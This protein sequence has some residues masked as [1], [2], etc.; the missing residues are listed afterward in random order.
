MSSSINPEETTF[1]REFRMRVRNNPYRLGFAET[2]RLLKMDRSTLHRDC[3][4]NNFPEWRTVLSLAL[5]FG[6]N[7]E[8]LYLLE[9][10]YDRD[11]RDKQSAT[12]EH[13]IAVLREQR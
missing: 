1:L 6:W 9:M 3:E 7:R 13:R 8:E 10:L 11:K 2:A 4:G 12:T 5:L